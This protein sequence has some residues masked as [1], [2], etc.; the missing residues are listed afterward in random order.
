MDSK[1][2][3]TLGIFIITIFSYVLNKIPMWVTAMTSLLLLVAS[4]ALPGELALAGF[5]NKNTILMACMFIISAGLRK[6]TFIRGLVKKIMQL[7]GGSFQKAYA[8][9]VIIT[10]LLANFISSPMVVF[11]IVAPLVIA[12]C[13]ENKVSPSKVLYAICITSIACTMTFPTDAAINQA[14]QNNAF[15]ESFGYGQFSMKATDFFFAKW[16]LLI[17]VPVWAIFFAPKMMPNKMVVEIENADGD[18]SKNSQTLNGLPDKAGII[19]FFATIIALVFNQFLPF[20]SWLIASIGALLMV[21]FNVLTSR[22]ALQAIPMDMICL[23]VG[24]LSLGAALNETGAG[25][26]IGDWLAKYAGGIKNNYLLGAIFFII[27]FMITQVMLN[28]AVVQI[29]T[30]ICILTCQALGVNPIGPMILVAVGSLTAFLTPMA[31]P[32]IPMCMGMGGYDLKSL[33][34]GG[35]LITIILTLVLIFYVMTIYP[36]Y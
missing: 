4:G 31:T 5:S 33:F 24:S 18:S 16:P 10:V 13:E 36:A 7:V 9:Y 35:W 29:F 32:A 3:I 22:E 2:L 1:V 34:K 20:D 27:P 15:L 21:Y 6:T 11:S 30:P 12:L 28:R 19:I 14:S 8:G 23:F 26:I 17:I 25:Q